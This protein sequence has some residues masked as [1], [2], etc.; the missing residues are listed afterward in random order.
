[1]FISQWLGPPGFF[2]RRGCA[3]PFIA[4]QRIIAALANPVVLVEAAGRS[5]SLLTTQ[6]AA[7]IGADIAVVPGRVTDPGGRQL[8]ELLRDGAHPIADAQDVLELIHGAGAHRAA[9]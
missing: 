9:A 1:M 4:S 7:E 8:L 3:W 2:P 6:I 5:C